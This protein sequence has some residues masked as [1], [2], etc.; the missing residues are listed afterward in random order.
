M[1][2][3]SNNR[4]IL[5]SALAGITLAASSLHAAVVPA[6]L[7]NDI[8]LGVRVLQG[9]EG[10]NP[11]KSTAYLVKIG[12]YSTFSTA[13]SPFTLDLGNIGSDLVRIYGSGWADRTDLYWGVFGTG[14]ENT[15]TVYSSL[16]RVAGAEVSIPGVLN[17]TERG[18]ARTALSSVISSDGLGYAGRESTL[19][20]VNG[21][22]LATEQ[23]GVSGAES[24]I[25]RVAT[26]SLDFRVWNSI[27]APVGGDSVL[28]LF[29]Y[30]NNGVDHAGYFSFG[31]D[32]LS[33]APVPE[34]SAALL[35]AAG[36][37]LLITSRRRAPLTKN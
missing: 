16:Q 17:S 34:P 25:T 29:R 3:R 8:F 37:F 2:P 20:G 27:E 32:G 7:V 26:E 30:R 12:T 28:D 9:D 24:Y 14:V 36:S 33:F 6:P 19:N 23:V 1:K 31:S 22:A 10:S 11:G 13:T 5:A 15:S 18:L 35:A 4:R 21:S